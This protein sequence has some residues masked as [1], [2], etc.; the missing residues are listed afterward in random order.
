MRAWSTE[1]N[2]SS[3]QGCLLGSGGQKWLQEQIF[4]HHECSLPASHASGRGYN[5]DKS[6]RQQ[7]WGKWSVLRCPG[8]WYRFR[9]EPG[10]M[11]GKAQ[12]GGAIA[13]GC[14]CWSLQKRRLSW[15][16]WQIPVKCQ[17]KW[18]SQLLP[19]LTQVAG[20][21][22]APQTEPLYSLSSVLA[23][24]RLAFTFSSLKK[25]PENV[26]HLHTIVVGPSTLKLG[27]KQCIHP[28]L[29]MCS[30]SLFISDFS[31][32]YCLGFALPCAAWLY[33]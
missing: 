15:E 33:F 13:G 8:K 5:K 16:C 23:G 22:V 12:P 26:T 19:W 7:L 2:F 24:G 10:W 3:S 31:M 1:Q 27:M 32:T 21:K 17:S 4:L 14:H 11:D 9:S 29:F 30:Y 18:M 6:S 28:P 25:G 20:D